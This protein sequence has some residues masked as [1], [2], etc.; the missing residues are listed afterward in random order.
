MR[1]RTLT[2][3][4]AVLAVLVSI[5]LFSPA[6]SGGGARQGRYVIGA[7]DDTTTPFNLVSVPAL[8]AHHYDGRGLHLVHMVRRNK[9]AEKWRIEYLGDGLRL[10]GTLLLPRTSGPHPVVV[11]MHGYLPPPYYR[12]GIGL[13]REEWRLASL[14]YVVLHPDYR[15]FGASWT[16]A[17][18]RARAIARPLGYPADVL[19]AVVALERARLDDV[20]TSRIG[21]FGRSMGGGIALQVAEARPTWFRSLLLYSPVS[22][23]AADDY[24][25][26]VAGNTSLER[27]V[28]SAYGTPEQDPEFWHEAS[29]AN[30]VDRLTMPVQIHH[31]A[32]DPICPVDWSR[33]T[34]DRMRRAGVDASMATYPG[35]VH[36]FTTQWPRF[37]AR[38]DRFFQRTL[39]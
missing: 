27:R 36:R 39:A 10:A 21:L 20:D 38:A 3:V 9:I 33:Q 31:G 15:N 34:Y 30:Y 5:L 4:A 16:R 26:W 23:V 19:N 22:A 29:S 17:S 13:V 1:S 18:G 2:P 8:V 32:A 11:S 24:D 6:V 12:N 14:G 7:A 28:T 25:R 37:M 35:Q